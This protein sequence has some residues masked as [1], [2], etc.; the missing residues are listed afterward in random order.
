MYEDIVNIWLGQGPGWCDGEV[1]RA[2]HHA[3]AVIL[4]CSARAPA[5]RGARVDLDLAVALR[6]LDRGHPR[7]ADQRRPPVVKAQT[8][9]EKRYSSITDV[10]NHICRLT[11]FLPPD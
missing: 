5:A 7:Q 10:R 4:L 11:P 1:E 9:Q 8:D 3:V 6:G 2:I